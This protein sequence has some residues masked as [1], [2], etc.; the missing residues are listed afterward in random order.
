M[1][2]LRGI[3]EVSR[4]SGMVG[5][6]LCVAGSPPA[7]TNIYL[8]PGF[9]WQGK[10]IMYQGK[11]D[12]QPGHQT[13]SVKDQD[14]GTSHS[15]HLQF[16]HSCYTYSSL[17]PWSRKTERSIWK[18][19]SDLTYLWSSSENSGERRK[20]VFCL[21]KVPVNTH[22]RTSASFVIK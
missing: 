15:V 18:M 5:P 12:I 22:I 7:F 3:W 13:V 9:A 4:L 1:G 17:H 2:V 11:S 19:H 6:T 10:V 14:L 21:S 16:G 20:F 8:I